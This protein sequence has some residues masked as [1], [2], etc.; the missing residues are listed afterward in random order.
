MSIIREKHPVQKSFDNWINLSDGIGHPSDE[1]R[2]FIFVKSVHHYH[3][4]KWRD[5]SFLRKKI[6]EKNKFLNREESLEAI[7]ELYD[8]LLK[9]CKVKYLKTISVV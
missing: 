2:F 6:L 7:L 9:F 5:A 1:R 3:A 4:T 8:Y